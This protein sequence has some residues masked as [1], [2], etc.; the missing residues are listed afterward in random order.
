MEFNTISSV[1]SL[2]TTKF[3]FYTQEADNIIQEIRCTQETARKYAV[4]KVQIRHHHSIFAKCL[5]TGLATH[6]TDNL[7]RHY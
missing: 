7:Y 5:S 4:M 6:N 1:E 2:R 3:D